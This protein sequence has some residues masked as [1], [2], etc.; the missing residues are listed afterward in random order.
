[1]QIFIY[2]KANLSTGE[3]V[4][5]AKNAIVGWGKQDFISKG[6]KCFLLKKG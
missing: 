1:M 4:I 5:R 3:F 6:K 2:R